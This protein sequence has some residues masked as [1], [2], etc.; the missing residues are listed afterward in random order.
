MRERF[1]RLLDR[2]GQT[3]RLVTGDGHETQAQVFLQPVFRQREEFPLS[4][5]ALGAVSRQ[6]WL[7]W[8]HAEMAPG[9]KL[10]CDGQHFA[11]QEVQLLR[12]GNSIL[13]RRATLRPWREDPA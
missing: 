9:D 11:V 7:C 6:R 8:S 10:T 4:A 1:Q 5:T 13:C 12:L 2:W 3:V